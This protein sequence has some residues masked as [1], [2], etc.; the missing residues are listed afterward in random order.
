MNFVPNINYFFLGR[1]RL[2]LGDTPIKTLFQFLQI[3]ISIWNWWRN[4]NVSTIAIVMVI[5]VKTGYDS[6]S[7]PPPPPPHTHTVTQMWNKCH[8]SKLTKI[9]FSSSNLQRSVLTLYYN[10][11]LCLVNLE[12]NKSNQWSE[13]FIAR[14]FVYK[15]PLRTVST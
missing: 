2:Q 6:T 7:P 8:N 14:K 4:L 10:K 12:N 1:L 11:Y 3:F 9:Y 13:H 15:I 5:Q